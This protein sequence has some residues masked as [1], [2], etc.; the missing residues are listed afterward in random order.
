MVIVPF[1]TAT[2]FITL[3]SYETSKIIHVTG[4]FCVFDR[5]TGTDTVVFL[6]PLAGSTPKLSA[7]GCANANGTNMPNIADTNNKVKQKVNR[8][9]SFPIIYIFLLWS[10]YIKTFLWKIEKA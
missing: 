3:L 9:F 7:A 1:L 4:P 5:V 6:Y 10:E 8:V 2:M